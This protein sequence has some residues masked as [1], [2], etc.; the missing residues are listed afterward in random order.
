LARE[1]SRVDR[2][3]EAIHRVVA[4]LLLQEVDDPRISHLTVSRVRVSRD[5]ANA[6]VFVV[7]PD[8]EAAAREALR[9]LRRAAGFLRRGVARRLMM[10]MVPELHFAPDT[11]LAEGNRVAALIEQAAAREEADEREGDDEAAGEG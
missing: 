11:S 3:E 5:L 1:F 10:R 2:V 7:L 8:D 9:A 6:K 4:E